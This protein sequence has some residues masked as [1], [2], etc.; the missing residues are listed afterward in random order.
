MDAETQ[1]VLFNAVPLLILAALYLA[2]GVAVAPALWRER[3]RRRDRLR[4]G[5]R[6]PVRGARR[7]RSWASRSWSTQ[8]PLA[9]N[10]LV[11][12]LGILLAAL[13]LV[14]IARN[15]RDRGLLVTGTRGA[16][17][18]EQQTSRRDREL[19]GVGR[20]SHRLLDADGPERRSR[21]CSSTS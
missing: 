13:P 10:A 14:A 17:E 8:E 1:A 16:R 4:D 18:P 15:W 19:A 7:R 3:G 20:L 12:L 9:G 5:A 11:A 21:A 2:V 6:L